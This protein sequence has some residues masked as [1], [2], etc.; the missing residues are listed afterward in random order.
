M[1][2]LNE[3]IIY[4]PDSAQFEWNYH[5][6]HEQTAGLYE[7]IIYEQAS[8]WLNRN[9]HLSTNQQLAQKKRLVSL[10][11]KLTSLFFNDT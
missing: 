7:I 3:V 6:T 4:L 1:A 2:T 8:D 5:S 10:T 9:N 11:V